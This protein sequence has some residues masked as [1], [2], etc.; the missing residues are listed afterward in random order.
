MKKI[1]RKKLFS[2]KNCF[3]S[4]PP[5][6]FLI[7]RLSAADFSQIIE[8]VSE[9]KPF[10]PLRF[11]NLFLTYFSPVGYIGKMGNCEL[12]R[13]KYPFGKKTERGG[14]IWKKKIEGKRKSADPRI[15]RYRKGKK[16]FWLHELG[17]G[18]RSHSSSNLAS[19]AAA[20]VAVQNLRPTAPSSP[21]PSLPLNTSISKKKL[22]G[23]EW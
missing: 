2:F 21:F 13:R 23:N 11:P 6:R 12:E 8:F 7:R 18:T 16:F 3:F 10:S 20:A 14:D 4:F 15:L 1:Q 17:R 19:A 5:G 22:P 9:K